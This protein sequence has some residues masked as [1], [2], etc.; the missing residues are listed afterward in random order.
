LP[1]VSL[2]LAPYHLFSPEVGIYVEGNQTD[3]C[4]FYPYPCANYWQR[5]VKPTYV[6]YFDENRQLVFG[7][8]A[9]IEV[10]GGWSKANPKKGLLLQFDH[11]DYGDGKVKNWP[12]LP[13][14]PNVTT[15]KNLH[16]RPGGN[17]VHSVFAHDAW[18]ERAFKTTDCDYIG[19]RPAHI[20]LNGAYWG[21]YELRERQDKH[22]LKY[23]Y[24]IDK[25]SV[26]ILRFPES[27]DFYGNTTYYAV[28]AGSDSIWFQTVSKMQFADPKSP[29]FYGLIDNEFDLSN[30]IDYHIVQTFIG[31]NDWLGPWFNNIRVWRPKTVDGKWRYMLWDLDGSMGEQWDEKYNPCFDNIN[32]A[33]NPDNDPI[34]HNWMFDKICKNPQFVARFAQRYSD[35]LNT[36]F[37]EK[38]LKPVADAIKN[39][40]DNDMSKN[41]TRWGGNINEWANQFDLNMDWAERRLGCVGGHIS[42]GLGLKGAISINY[43]TQPENAGI[44]S[45][46]VADSIATTWKGYFFKDYPI[47]VNIEAKDGFI[48]SHWGSKGALLENPKASNFE[49]L[50]DKSTELTAYF[51]PKEK[52]PAF[53]EG[54]AL[55]PN[56]AKE[57]AFIQSDTPLGDCVLL[58]ALGQAVLRFKTEDAF[59]SFNV[60]G[61]PSGVYWLE[62]R[63]WSRAI[64]KI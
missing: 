55:F 51:I 40:L 27:S 13:D 31:N 59:G 58:D 25:D 46:N 21:I 38:N 18:L 24:G 64:L 44:A 12:L 47:K 20:F 48:F 5:W 37:Q 10:T 19:Y 34:E 60:I 4:D 16:L 29:D 22:F 1:V 26:D 43:K 14:K 11:D 8:N 53:K 30:Y 57:W 32:Y 41:F 9:G 28:Q 2:T 54:A 63:E 52:V 62:T 50:F 39:E 15:W 49:Q 17:G 42:R 23:N 36:V 35:L 7:Q 56:P 45:F 6:E 33:R 61:L 3:T